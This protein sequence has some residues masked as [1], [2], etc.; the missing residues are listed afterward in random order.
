[1]DW[2]LP[3]GATV[4]L[5]ELPKRYGGRL[6]GRIR[7]SRTEHLLMIS[8]TDASSVRD[9]WTGTRYLFTGEGSREGHHRIAQGNAALLR[10][11]ETG[12]TLRLF[13]HLGGSDPR[14][15]G[16]YAVDADLPFVHADLPGEFGP[17]RGMVFRLVPL[18]GAPTGVRLA[19]DAPGKKPRIEQTD[20]DPQLLAADAD[21]HAPAGIRLLAQYCRYQRRRGHSLARL[22]VTP[23]GDLTAICSDL[24][25]LTAN[26]L[27]T[28]VGNGSR[29]ALHR[30]VGM[31]DDL[32]R[33][34][35]PGVGRALLLATKPDGD[36]F[37]LAARYGLT[38]TWPT[39]NNA[40]ARKTQPRPLQI[41]T[42][43]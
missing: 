31:L 32:A 36:L 15:L 30:A 41:G 33:Y 16:R 5:K 2:D 29:D 40:F 24:Y 43:A 39:D 10:H 9:G 38:L 4:P 28:V 22:T 7:P 23:V 17:V 11:Q 3:I 42:A 1:M 14:Y 27:V 25:D 6:Q 20:L 8:G 34:L 35:D 19:V 37:R 26:E 13:H 18:D 21:R 12:K